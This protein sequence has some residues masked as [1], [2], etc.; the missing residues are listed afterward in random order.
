[1]KY[2]LF[3]SG[4]ALLLSYI[5]PTQAQW[6]VNAGAG[7]EFNDNLPN[8]RLSG[9]IKSDNA[10]LANL[11]AGRYFQLTDSTGLALTADLGG[12]TYAR[13]D[14]L[15]N[16]FYGATAGLKQ[17]FGLG[18][19][20]PWIRLSG[21]AAYHDFEN[22]PRDGWRY[23]L[24]AGIGK[25]LSERW[26]VQLNYRYEERNSDHIVNIPFL[27]NNFGIGGDAFNIAAHNVSL[28]GIFTVTDKLTAYLGYTR[29][30]GDVT[31]TSREE[32]EIFEYS[33]AVAVDNAFGKDTFA[34]R[35]QASTNIFSAGLSWALTNHASLNIGY[36]RQDSTVSKDVQYT[37]NTGRLN[38][39]YRF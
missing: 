21:S 24:S 12:T 35:V 6:L 5:T 25:R 15:N 7:Y 31:S 32:E 10:F 37:N 23:N 9:D 29:R 19:Y 30:E 33:D 11:S 4:I 2:R 16:V 38:L 3:L 1:M 26:E 8:A 34:Y 27:V 28:T 39:L 14:G 36:D 22:D 13:F 20:A 17:K 18:E